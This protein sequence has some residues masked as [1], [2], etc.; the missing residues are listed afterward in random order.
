[1]FN[2]P[3]EWGCNSTFHARS[4][5]QIKVIGDDFDVIVV[6]VK[7][8]RLVSSRRHSA[9]PPLPNTDYRERCFENEMVRA[10]R[11]KPVACGSISDQDIEYPALPPSFSVAMA[12]G[13]AVSGGAVERGDFW[14]S[15]GLREGEE[16][17]RGERGGRCDAEV[18]VIEL[19]S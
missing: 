7:G 4:V 13:A 10:Y 16:G 14:W 8:H 9:Q 19:K 6:E 12:N 3:G 15:D 17:K 18:M 2:V 11:I 1:M 5:P